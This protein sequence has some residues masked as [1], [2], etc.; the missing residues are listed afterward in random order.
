M[1]KCTNK[2]LIHDK[3]Y[4]INKV[5]SGYI[6]LLEKIERDQINENKN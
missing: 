2:N 4:F 3:T 6:K 1:N 5:A